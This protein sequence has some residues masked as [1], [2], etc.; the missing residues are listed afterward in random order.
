MARVRQG[1]VQ[2]PGKLTSR[3]P[4]HS[5][6]AQEARRLLA[7][8]R[9]EIISFLQEFVRVNSV[10][11]PPNG[12]ET[13]AQKVAYRFFKAHGLDVELYDVGFLKDSK[14]PYVRR[15]RQYS[16]RCNLIAR[17]PG[18]GRGRSLLLTGHVDTVPAGLAPWKESPW[19]GTIRKGRL[20]GRGSFDMKGGLAANFA[21]AIAL[22]KA[23]VRL[24]GDLLCESVVDE[25]Y[26][27]GGG[28]LAAR[29]RGDIADACVIT[30]PTNLAIY[31]ATRGGY[32]FDILTGAGDPKGYFS[33]KEVISPAIPMG[34]LLGWVE[35]WARKRRRIARG[36]V[37]RDFP[38]PAPVQVLALE[39]NHFH[40]EVPLSVPLDARIRIYFQFL[41]HED[42]PSVIGE[43][44]KSFSSFCERDP[45]F[46][47]YAPEWQTLVDSPLLGHELA[48]DHKWTQCLFRNVTACLGTPPA[49]TGAEYPCDAFVFQREFGIPT[50]LFGPEGG[51]AHNPD[52]YVR[53]R[54]VLQTAEALL[55][56]ALE[57][58]GG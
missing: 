11:V 10:A 8:I 21:V 43:I 14:H 44:R 47:I 18:T 35:S 27:G 40:P 23:K 45:F 29:L 25:E 50:L 51:G 53:V 12:N 30:E 13:Q 17:Y 48:A 4:R 20:Y 9:N 26:A 31:R 58:C 6:V 56:A 1:N 42:V 54:S 39:A 36:G 46:S 3:L 15:E 22:K 52:E 38:D 7:P 2:D 57:W 24:G 55:A 16:G 28:T 49:L 19:S 5:R 37:Y 32:I 34:R 33:K 41:P